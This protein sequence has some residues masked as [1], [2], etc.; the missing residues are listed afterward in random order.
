MSDFQKI[1]AVVDPDA[2]SQKALSRALEIAEKTGASVTALLTTYDSSYEF[3]SL[4]SAKDRETLRQAAVDQ[5]TDW[6]SDL[7]ETVS[8]NRMI[9][10]DVKVVWHNRPYESIIIEAVEGAYDLI[11]KGT[12]E[13]DTLKAVIFTPTDW[14]ILRKAPTPVLLVKDHEWLPNG[15][16]IAAVN[17]GTED[18]DHAELNHTICDVTK[19]LGQVFEANVNL[20]NAY[21]G[22]PVNIAI[23]IP[24]FDPH[25]YNESIKNYHLE[26]IEKLGS[27]Y[28]VQ[29]DHCFVKEGLPEDVIPAVARNIDAE[30]VVIGTVGRHGISAALIGNTA[31]HVI[32]RLNC[33]VLALKPKDFTC[34]LIK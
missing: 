24:E 13:H 9:S 22:T 18:P 32:D 27:Q 6:L 3:T 34:P 10:V 28:Q 17:A 1:L 15:Q 5:R 31:E 33:D 12:Q 26:S 23:E 30:L 19:Q 16:I 4:L 2:D 11:V 29:M 20:V 21:P 25:D 14:H 8:Q 7:V